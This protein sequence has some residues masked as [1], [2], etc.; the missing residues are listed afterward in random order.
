MNV[1]HNLKGNLT[2]NVAS[3]FFFWLCSLSNKD[4]LTDVCLRLIS[5]AC[6]FHW[7]S[8]FLLSGALSWEGRVDDTLVLWLSKTTHPSI[9]IVFSQCATV[10]DA[11]MM[12]ADHPCIISHRNKCTFLQTESDSSAM[13]WKSI[14]AHSLFFFFKTH[15]YLCHYLSVIQAGQYLFR[16]LR[17]DTPV[18]IVV[19]GIINFMFCP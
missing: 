8:F 16:R 15:M 17:R 11:F 7:W 1:G 18:N 4:L 6:S 19:T 9:R 12:K 14:H 2:Y 10:A 3:S 13:P 5:P